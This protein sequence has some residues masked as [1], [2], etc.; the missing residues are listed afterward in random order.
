MVV[1]TGK[2]DTP[3]TN[4]AQRVDHCIYIKT[5]RVW[6]VI[7]GK[8]KNRVKHTQLINSIVFSGGLCLIE[9]SALIQVRLPDPAFAGKTLQL[10]KGV[11]PQNT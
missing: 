9:A 6:E 8:K 11:L 10:F 7:L 1:G 2:T 4:G 5:D 3:T